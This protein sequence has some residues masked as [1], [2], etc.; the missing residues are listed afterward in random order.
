MED[1]LDVDKVAQYVLHVADLLA[2]KAVHL[3]LQGVLAA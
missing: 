3:L 2:L 1:E